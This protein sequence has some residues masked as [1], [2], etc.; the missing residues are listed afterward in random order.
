MRETFKYSKKLF[1]TEACLHKGATSCRGQDVKGNLHSPYFSYFQEALKV[2][3]PPGLVGGFLTA[4]EAE[5]NANNL[6]L[7]SLNLSLAPVFSFLSQIHSE[8]I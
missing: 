6:A 3:S 5:M 1:I 4:G 7:E 8:N 2:V